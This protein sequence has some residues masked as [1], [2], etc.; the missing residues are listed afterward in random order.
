MRR[1]RRRNKHNRPFWICSPRDNQGFQLIIE[2]LPLDFRLRPT[3]HY[4][5]LHD[6]N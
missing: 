5:P 1:A 4:F 3:A 6:I 2:K